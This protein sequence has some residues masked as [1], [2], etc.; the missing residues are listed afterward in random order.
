[1][2]K[3]L[4]I[5][6]DNFVILQQN[7]GNVQLMMTVNCLLTN[8]PMVFVF[9]EKGCQFGIQKKCLLKFPMTSMNTTQIWFTKLF[10]QWIAWCAAVSRSGEL[11]SS[12]F[13]DYH[14]FKFKCYQVLITFQ[15]SRLATPTDIDKVVI[16]NDPSQYGCFSPVGKQ[17]G[18]Q[19]I[20]LSDECFSERK[21]A[22]ELMHSIGFY[23]EHARSDRDQYVNIHENCIREGNEDE[24]KIY[25]EA[26]T[27]GLP[28]NHKSVMH[29]QTLEFTNKRC[30][31]IT[32]K[33][34]GVTDF[35]LGSAENLND[36]D[37]QKLL[38]MY[39]CEETSKYHFYYGIWLFIELSFPTNDSDH[40]K[41]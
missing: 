8:V 22:H 10:Q 15:F 5:N 33:M 26:L 27:Y 41:S 21:I 2:S 37:I 13:L 1:M 38:K 32:S 25:P 12:F 31:P 16:K 29:Y 17:N 36:L 3:Y 14:V 4:S 30:A 9:L 40:L 39:R 6:I 28:Y 7:I 18:T 20:Q 34:S 23:H 19:I 24:F 35:E 11:S